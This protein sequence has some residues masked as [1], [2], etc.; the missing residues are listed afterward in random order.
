[1]GNE[2]L[3]RGVEIE[4]K[5]Y[6]TT[7]ELKLYSKL[8]EK[9]A[10]DVDRV[11]DFLKEIDSDVAFTNMGFYLE[12]GTVFTRGDETWAYGGYEEHS[13]CFDAEMLTWTDEELRK[14]VDQVKKGKEEERVREEI[15]KARKKEEEERSLWE[16]LNEKF[17]K[18]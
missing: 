16:K 2:V 6:M 17:G 15:E 3:G 18:K 4:R 7:E 8:Q 9:F 13:G 5:K 14:Y 12:D 10:A 11:T 1:M